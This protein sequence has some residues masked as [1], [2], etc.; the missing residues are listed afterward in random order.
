MS[1]VGDRLSMGWRLVI[2]GRWLVVTGQRLVVTGWWLV[3]TARWLVIIGRWLVFAVVWPGFKF[4]LC[5]YHF[6]SAKNFANLK[7]DRRWRLEL[8]F[9]HSRSCQG[10][11]V[12]QSENRSKRRHRLISAR[13]MQLSKRRM[14]T[15]KCVI[16]YWKYI[17]QQNL[18]GHAICMPEAKRVS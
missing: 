1:Q 18:F 6:L 3:V 7:N 5:K 17:G 12:T 15:S 13:Q 9:L 2:T 11:Q 8:M 16:Q 14:R 10:L 4:L